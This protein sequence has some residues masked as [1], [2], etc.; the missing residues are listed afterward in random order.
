[1][2]KIKLT[3]FLIS[4]FLLFITPVQA[5]HVYIDPEYQTASIGDT[6]TVDIIVD[7][8]EGIGV[9]GAQYNL[10]FDNTLLN[11]TDQ[12]TGPFLSQD[13]ANTIVFWNNINNTIE[14][15]G[16]GESRMMEVYGVTTPG[17]LTT[18]TFEVIAE[19]GISELGLS[20][21]HLSDNDSNVIPTTYTN[22]SVDIKDYICGDVDGIEG[23]TTNDGWLIFKNATNPG[24]PRYI[25]SC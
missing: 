22:G 1:M 4:I 10:S 17:I 16:Y 2:Y 11:A 12:N 18:V 3:I 23:V 14:I 8:E 9:Y 13:G 20:N 21:V 19:E 25:I 5:A 7:P 6:I 15:V 24:D